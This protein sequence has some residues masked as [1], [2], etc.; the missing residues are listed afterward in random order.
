MTRRCLCSMNG[1]FVVGLLLVFGGH[2]VVGWNQAAVIADEPAAIDYP[3]RLPSG[4]ASETFSGSE[5][6]ARPATLR[7]EVEMAKTPPLVDFLYFPEQDYPGNPWSNWGDSLCIGDKY[8]ASIGDHRAPAGNA[9]VFEYDPQLK[10]FRKLLDLKELLQLPDGH[11]APAKIHS[12]LDLGQDGWLYCSTHRGSPKSTNDRNHYQGDWIVR[13][14][15]ES[16]RAE[17]VA[18]APVSKHCLPASVLDPTRLIFYA[19]TAPGSDAVEQGIQFLAYDVARRRVLYRGDNGPPRC[20]L[21][22]RSTGRVYFTPGSQEDAPLVRFD[23][24]QGG[25]P[26]T[27]KTVLGARAATDETPQRVIYT[28]SSGQAQSD[29]TIW[30][31]HTDTEQAENLGPSSVG[32]QGYVA[33]IDADR[34]GRYLYYV[35]GAHGGSEKD[36]A[37]V[38]QFDTQT[39]R[40]KVLCTLHPL[41][42]NRLGCTLKGTY[43]TALNDTGTKLFICWNASRGSKAWDSCALTV[44]HIPASER[45]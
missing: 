5:L 29:P 18:H 16:G 33:S 13:C 1:L 36:S 9:R 26:V 34:S 43:S 17:V 35:P 11:Y 22:A 4:A 2:Y 20:L 23:P 45:P 30:A 14:H 6:L 41:I 37:A 28:I 24:A 19:G 31:F 42:A 3:P 12:R 7:A 27:I 32:S 40:R 8:Y 15:P 10:R 39:R 44:I 38:V 21:L 25:A